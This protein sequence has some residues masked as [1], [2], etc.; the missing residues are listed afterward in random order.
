MSTLI[1]TGFD[2]ITVLRGSKYIG[3]WDWE[4]CDFTGMTAIVKI[5]NIHPEFNDVK[6]A[7]E[8]GVATVCPLDVD[9][10]PYINRIQ[11]ELS[12]EDTLKFAIPASEDFSFGDESGYYSV[13]NII[14]DDGTVVLTANVK[15][16]NSI[17]AET[18]DFLLDEKDE[19]IIINQKL[20]SLASFNAEFT[21]QRDA[22]LQTLSDAQTNIDMQVEDITTK[23]GEINQ[24]KDDVIA[25]KG[26]IETIFDNF[27]DRYLGPFDT[28]PI[29]DNDGEA[30]AVGAIYLDTVDKELKFYNGVSWDSPVAAAQTYAQQASQSAS[31]ANQDR[32]VVEQLESSVQNLALQVTNDKQA[33]S[34]DKQTVLNAKTDVENIRDDLQSSVDS[35]SSKVNISDVQDLLNSTDPTK[36]LSANQG[37]ILKGFI[38]N[39]NTVLN[40]DDTTLDE[41]Q[42]IVSFIKQNKST[43]D[44]LSIS[45]IAGLVDALNNIYLK[46]ETYSKTQ[47]DDILLSVIPAGTVIHFA[48]STVPAGFLELNGAELSRTV[49]A[50]LFAV[51]GTTGGAGDGSTTFNLRDARGEFIRGWDNGRGVDAGR[52]IGSYQADAYLNHSHTGS[53]GSQGAHTHTYATLSNNVGTSST[54]PG[55]SGAVNATTS[56]SGAHTH[57]ITVNASTTGSTETR[58]RNIAMMYCIKY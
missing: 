29:L 1:P 49:Y 17:E 11:I 5:K 21:T 40:S 57:T 30:L 10:N 31:A 28:A 50:D 14:L 41:L 19:A 3:V 27:D 6:N 42:E 25:L 33:V 44:S 52:T 13:L 7:Y 56:T 20:D 18:L 22:Y 9:N 53:T 46:S 54:T 12:K 55:G 47:V 2:N 32:V 45:N 38:D 26:Q 35:I 4:D 37:R 24:I 34:L 36:P 58:P 8:V 48:G 23:H 16:V 15:V 51:V 39:I 43:L